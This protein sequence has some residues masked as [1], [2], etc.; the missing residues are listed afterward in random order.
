MTAS[1][2]QKH[3]RHCL[4]THDDSRQQDARQDMELEIFEG[5]FDAPDFFSDKVA[6]PTVECQGIGHRGAPITWIATAYWIVSTGAPVFVTDFLNRFIVGSG[7]FAL[8]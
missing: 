8:G 2:C 7:S 4:L 6:R 1:N 3:R 5:L